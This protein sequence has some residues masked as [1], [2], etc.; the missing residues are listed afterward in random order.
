VPMLFLS[1]MAFLFQAPRPWSF[2]ISNHLLIQAES[3]FL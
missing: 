2:R 1:A 3:Q